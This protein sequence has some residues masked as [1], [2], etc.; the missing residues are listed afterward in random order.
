MAALSQCTPENELWNI[1]LTSLTEAIALAQKQ[2]KTPLILDSGDPKKV[3][4]TLTC[5][6]PAYAR[7]LMWSFGQVD[8]FFSYQAALTIDAKKIMVW[9]VP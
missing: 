7:T 4:R 2:G 5:S 6:H 9:A 8:V 3:D 1:P